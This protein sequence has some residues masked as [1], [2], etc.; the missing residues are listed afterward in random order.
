MR[1]VPFIRFALGICLAAASPTSE[2]PW[3]E[4]I[5]SI[6]EDRGFSGDHATLCLVRVVN[7]GRGT[8]PG[9]KIRFEA[10][11][12]RDGRVADRQSGSFGLTLGPH[13]TL[14][15]R[16]GFVGRFDRFEVSPGGSRPDE[17]SGRRK[18]GKRKS[19]PHGTRVRE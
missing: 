16:I 9:R 4:L 13:E 11:A 2:L 7:G 17:S 1:C 5:L 10:R 15:T 6:E 14:E 3:P 18:K 12:I 8:W 19:T